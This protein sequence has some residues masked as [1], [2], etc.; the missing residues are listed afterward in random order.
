MKTSCFQCAETSCQVDVKDLHVDIFTFRTVSAFVIKCICMFSHFTIGH[1]GCM[2]R[3]R[4]CSCSWDDGC[5]LMLSHNTV[6]VA[7]VFLLQK[8]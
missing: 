1:H 4:T 7:L 6:P 2:T 5:T 3:I 8:M